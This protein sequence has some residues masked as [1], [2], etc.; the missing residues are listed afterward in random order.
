MS[1]SSNC[2]DDEKLQRMAFVA[3]DILMT[4]ENI[5]VEAG[6]NFN[7]AYCNQQQITFG[8]M[9]NNTISLNLF[10]DGGLSYADI[11]KNF[12]L[13]VGVEDYRRTDETFAST[14]SYISHSGENFQLRSESPYLVTNCEIGTLS[15]IVSNGFPSKMLWFNDSLYMIFVSGSNRWYAKHNRTASGVYGN[16]TA[17][18]TNFEKGFLDRIYDDSGLSGLVINDTYFAEYYMTN[19]THTAPMAGTVWN[20]FLSSTWGDWQDRPWGYFAS[21]CEMVE[22]HYETK[23]FGVWK[24]NKPRR[25]N[26]ALLPLEGTDKMR[27]FDEDSLGFIRYNRSLRKGLMTVREYI[28][29][30]ADYK[31]IPVGDLSGLNGLADEI[32]VDPTVYYNQKSLKDLLSYAFEVGASNAFFDERGRLS[33]GVSAI[34]V[35]RED[36][37][38]WYSADIADE[39]SISITAALIYLQGDTAIYEGNAS[40]PGRYEWSDNP[41]FNKRNP[42]ASYFS[43]F[44]NTRYGNYN[45]TILVTDSDYSFFGDVHIGFKVGTTLYFIPIF[46]MS[47]FW[48][49]FGKTTYCSY[50][51]SKRDYQSYAQRTTSVTNNND[52][53]LQGF[54]QANYNNKVSFSSDGLTVNSRGLQIK[55][56]SG[57]VV[58]DADTNGNL[59][60]RGELDGATGTFSGQ[61]DAASGK[62]VGEVIADSG[63][64]TGEVNAT[65]GT[66]NGVV[67]ASSGVFNGEVN[68]SSG[69]FTGEVHASSGEFTG[70]VNATSGKIANWSISGNNLKQTNSSD[71]NEYVEMGKISGLLTDDVIG[72]RASGVESSVRYD[73]LIY[74]AGLMFFKAGSPMSFIRSMGTSLTIQS[75]SVDTKILSGGAL[76]LVSGSS[77]DVWISSGTGG[78]ISMS[79]DECDINSSLVK[80][81]NPP[82]F[83]NVASTTS[84]SNTV[85]VAGAY[86]RKLYVTSSLR[87]LKKNIKT[88]EN[89][90]E[91]VDN[92]RG[93]SFTSKCEVD[94]PKRVFYGFIAEEVE[95]AVPELATY[96]DGKLQSVQYD[97]VCALLVE[98][99]KAMHKRISALE[100]QVEA[101]ESMIKELKK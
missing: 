3:D 15:P 89:P 73:G 37:P 16:Y 82:W 43:N 9:I 56:A 26:D 46:T 11:N 12:Q 66:F 75:N 6:V 100:K 52:V 2:Y 42:S 1:F 80:V 62:F 85:L 69:S 72:I 10:N 78:K 65:S 21:Y 60:I 97:R 5:N 49:G 24:F 91:K 44:W 28:K 51:S 41:F 88:I 92:L 101:L 57:Q 79:G 68:A 84:G 53:S 74:K 55:N 7:L 63:K 93:V 98:D 48:N 39:T 36:I 45:E 33:G 54:N 95:K 25:I 18:L 40:D 32:K 20:S 35:A 8:E 94:D 50:G 90:S 76:W 4:N 19:V 87:A 77:S 61:L 67:N 34:P 14:I 99:N 86:G 58:F 13:Y 17:S 83:N 71:T 23:P 70:Q 96:E 27:L 30:I 81:D 59:R 22:Y 31:N 38:Y 47:V 29:A 64:F